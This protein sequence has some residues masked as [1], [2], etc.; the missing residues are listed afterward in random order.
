MSIIA[1]ALENV[2]DR[3]LM[4]ELLAENHTVE[5]IGTD[6]VLPQG[7]DLCIIDAR[8][9]PRMATQ[10]SAR[11]EEQ[12]VFLPFLFAASRQDAKM[13]TSRLWES[14]DELVTVPVEKRELLARVEVL[15]RTRRLSMDL[16]RSNEDLQQ[17][18]YVASHDLQEPL[19]MVTSYVQLLARRYSDKLDADA[20]EFIDF[21]VQGAARMQ[22]LIND[23]LAYSRVSTRAEPP[24]STDCQAV[25]AEVMS[26][27]EVAI[28]ESGAQIKC[29]PLPTVMAD[30]GQLSQVF[31][32]LIG[33]A[34]KFRGEEPPRISVT[35]ECVLRQAQDAQGEW[36]F[37]VRDNGIGIPL[38]HKDS[39][40]QVFE[41]LHSREQ[42]PGS[43][44]G[45]AVCK[46]IVEW[47]GGRIW[48]DSVLGAGST[49]RF[50]LP[51]GEVVQ[52]CR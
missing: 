25:M 46:R 30:R 10:I 43:G 17:F 9:L 1:I 11:K 4:S 12:P 5:E 41:R 34:I 16:R 3:E 36:L 52:V 21:A 47:H 35:A 6:G 37:S 32:N 44:I 48:V 31:Q 23:L 50:T 18:A 40:F 29:G 38:E 42:Y 20:N 51:I 27:L 45:L 49:F 2:K 33:N 26:N 39:I 24:K 22:T 15:L 13:T 28:K 8:S 14:V 7:F 19:R